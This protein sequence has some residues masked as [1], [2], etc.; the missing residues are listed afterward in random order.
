VRFLLGVF[1]IAI[2]AASC[3]AP[4]TAAP[5][6]PAVAARPKPSLPPWIASISPLEKAQS[7]AQIRI[8]FAKPMTPVEALSGAGPT[9]VLAHLSIQPELHGHFSVL[10][11]RMVGFVAEQAL[12]TGT[13]VAV[14]LSTGL[15]DL[16][17]DK[18]DHDL[19]WTFETGALEFSDLPQVSPSPDEPTPQPVGLRPVLKITANAAVDVASLARHATL[20]AAGERIPLDAT[21]EAQP[22]PIPGSGAAEL[23]DPS[24]RD[25]IYELRPQHDLRRA[26]T[27]ALRIAPGV[28]PAY[29]NVPTSRAFEGAIR[30]YAPLDIEPTATPGSSVGF[31]F[32]AGDPVVA[33]NNPLDPKSIAGAVEISPAPV[34]VKALTT[35]SDDQGTIVID[36]YALGPDATYAVRISAN[37]RDVFGQTLGRQR[38]VTIRT[39]DFAPGE[40]AP[41]G[42]SVIPAGA[43]VELNFYAT[44][45]PGNGYQAAFARVTPQAMLGG[46]DPLK[47]LPDP[48]N[49][50]SS[51]LAGAK[52]NIQSVVRVPLQAQLGSEYGALAYGFRS[53]L[54]P[55]DQ[56]P[57][58]VGIAQ[59]TNLG[60]FAQ[61]F[62]ARGVIL[63]QHLSDGAPA[64]NVAV[65]AFRM[66]SSGTV[67]GSCARGTTN[68]DGELEFTG[69]D[70]ERCSAG[71]QTNQAP[72]IGLLAQEGGDVATL[73]T[74]SWSGVYRFNVNGGWS[75]G[76]P[77]SRGTIFTDRQ[78]YQ[79]G[80]RGEMTGI[81]YYVSGSRVV[82]DKN[83]TYRV[84]LQDPSNNVARL[85]AVKTDAYGVF[86][87]PLL[88]SKQQALGYYTIAAKGESGNEIDG[89]LRIAQ[90]KPPNFK[91]D[92]TLDATSATA[93][94]SVNATAKA[95]YLF[96]APLQGGTAHAYV[97][98][99]LAAVAPKGWD[100]FS[101]GRQWFW[102]EETPSIPT[103]VLQRDLALD[104]TGTAALDVAVP[105]DL[106]FPMEYNVDVEATDVS[107]LS[108]ADSKSF[109]AL[110]SDAVIGIKSDVAGTVGA[111]LSIGAIVTDA[112]GHPI[113]GRAVHFAL[114]KMTYTSATQEVEGG[115]SAQQSVEYTTVATADANSA[116]DPIAISL[117]P[118]DAGPYRLWANFAGA[119]DASATDVQLF[120]F[121]PGEADWGLSDPN[122]VAVKLDKKAYAVGDTATALIAVPFD[123]ADMYVAVIRGDVLYRTVLRGV[124]GGQRVAFKITPDMLPNAAVE[125]V[126]VRRGPSLASNAIGKLDTLSRV[127][128]AGFDVDVTQ[129]NLKLRIAP[130]AATVTP[131]SAQRVDFTLARKDGKPAQGEIVAMV[132]NDAILQL[133][134]YRLPDLVETVFAD[135]PISTIFSD[136]REGIV[137][138]TPTPPLEKGFGYGGGYL[139]GAASTRVRQHFLPLAYYGVLRTDASGKSSASFTMPDDLTTWRVMAVAIGSD[140]A[141]FATSD[142]TFLSNQP[143]ITNPLLPQFARPGDRFDA[144]ISVA[145]QTGGGG[146]LDLVLQLTGALAFVTGNPRALRTSEN[147]QT[148]VQAWRFGVIAG[149]PA[150]T[151]FEASTTLRSQH[152]AFRVPFETIERS[153][154]ESVIESGAT[155]ATATI[156]IALRGGWVQLTL[157]NS[158]VSQFTAPSNVMMSDD[159]LPFAD[160]AASRL[161]VAAALE[162]LRTQYRLELDFIPQEQIAA[163][164]QQLYALQRDDGGFGEFANAQGSDP[165]VSARAF[166]ALLFAGS[167]AVTVDRNRIARA[168]TYLAQT[169]A[170]PSRYR[171]CA[172]EE[173]KSQ[174]RFEVLWALAANG[175]RRTDFLSDVV[176]HS[177]DFDSA[178]QIRLARYLLQ[179]PGWQSRGAEMANELEQTLYITGRYA[180][181]GVSDPWDWLDSEVDAQ[182]Q[183]LQL[184]LERHAPPE[185]LDGAVRALVAQQCRCGWPTLDDAASA[186]TA[187]SA[188]AAG[189]SLHP[190]S[191]TATVGTAKVATAQFGNTASSQTFRFR[192]DALRGSAVSIRAGGGTVHY[193]LLYTYPI[194]SDAP[195]QL[196]A[197]RVV[198]QVSVPGA[199]PTTLATMDLQPAAAVEVAAGRVFDIGVRVIVDHPVDRLLIEDPLPAGFE[200]V[201]TTFRTSLGA[202]LPQTDSWEIDTQQLYRDRVVGYAD[203][204]GPGVYE[205]HY[206]ARSVTPGAYQWPGAR[207]YL[208][209]APEQSGRSAS[210]ELRVTP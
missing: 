129:R 115:E 116:G 16:S 158:V 95:A 105:P 207:A 149:T 164:L 167:H 71:A 46:A 186:V 202:V 127:G 142:A 99:D 37:V 126:I 174:L 91:L 65:T 130:R 121:G 4:E 2:A 17:G 11:P 120:A 114:Q 3:G 195:G 131:G 35:L 12:P 67:L 78:L 177:S 79:P 61:W 197:F 203:H 180:V 113:T 36:P 205:M 154:T 176:A 171:W 58:N 55:K 72:A 101:F 136:N 41:S 187:L 108:V 111:P 196:G 38:T 85:G 117:T 27:Y 96:G 80:E 208:R 169:L 157:A 86:S 210:S 160:D 23:F 60:V 53:E 102:P 62:P 107:N 103:D 200:A 59:L 76:A 173:C 133:S 49:W 125:A 132:V 123:D 112:D 1:V 83:A 170:N 88:F 178:T 25:W 64:P 51:T 40:W 22:T 89:A 9:S 135:Q 63:V 153:T 57:S 50:G 156:P 56:S 14:T 18:L 84:T 68:A 185:Q 7:L 87:M 146:A 141:H 13:R 182:S 109:L 24:L 66:D 194:P 166:A 155:A 144:G 94:A 128:M 175:D 73:V 209:D 32:A 34:R 152:D 20:T 201:D 145:D 159:A 19:V 90:F 98:R 147:A 138:K 143:L 31:R 140:N 189:E 81:A 43:P 45:L 163:A 168:S 28:D 106:P 191:A 48:S 42:T 110:P 77:L 39:S 206:L 193:T 192:A 184:L 15:R 26:T 10:T 74:Q 6:L 119:S 97:T 8:I 172:G 162:P 179:T 93:G 148:G 150:P 5:R 122:A 82:A 47:A 190:S 30:T 124:S 188:Y 137:L 54:D 198:R 151:T 134:G 21:L 165:F 181:A 161:I 104:T 199:A 70:V 92:L 118:P 44:N 33:F 139:A 204:L 183:M 29:G 75:S 100:E 69:I 52:R